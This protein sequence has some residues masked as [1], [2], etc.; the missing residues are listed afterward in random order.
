M[1]NKAITSHSVTDRISDHL[2]SKVLTYCSFHRV[3]WQSFDI[4]ILLRTSRDYQEQDSTKRSIW[5]TSENDQHFDQHQQLSMRTTDETIQTLI[6][7]IMNSVMN[8][9]VSQWFHK[10]RHDW[11]TKVNSAKTEE[12]TQSKEIFSKK[13]KNTSIQRDTEML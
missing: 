13:R 1:N 7:T 4:T 3:R 2:C 10:F 6:K 11:Q 5:R 12:H 9:S 8:Q